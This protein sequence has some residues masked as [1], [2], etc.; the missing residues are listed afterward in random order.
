LQR[1]IR[2]IFIGLLQ[3]YDDRANLGSASGDESNLFLD[4]KRRNKNGK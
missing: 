1:F 4:K 2:F 3:E